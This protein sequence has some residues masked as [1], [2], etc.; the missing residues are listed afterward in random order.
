MQFLVLGDVTYQLKFPVVVV[1]ITQ[2]SNLMKRTL[3]VGTHSSSSFLSYGD[4]PGLRGTL[5]MQFSTIKLSACLP[6]LF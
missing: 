5:C 6:S 2:Y 1:F 3:V 4:V